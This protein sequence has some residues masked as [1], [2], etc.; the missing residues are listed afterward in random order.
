[1]PPKRRSKAPPPPSSSDSGSDSS[2]SGDDDTKTKKTKTAAKPSKAPYANVYSLTLD[3]RHADARPIARIG[4]TDEPRYLYL[5]YGS[6]DGVRSFNLPAS[7]TPTTTCLWPTLT[8]QLCGNLANAYPSKLFIAGASLSGKSYLASKI[9]RAFMAN[10]PKG[11]RIVL[12]SALA[13]DKCFDDIERIIGEERFVRLPVDDETFNEDT[14]ISLSDV[15][16]DPS[17]WKGALVIIDDHLSASSKKAVKAAERLKDSILQAGRHY[18]LSLI[19]CQQ[20]MLN[21]HQSRTTLTN[22]FQVCGYPASSG[23]HSLIAFQKKYMAMTDAQIADNMAIPS[24]W[25]LF[26]RVNPMFVMHERGCFLL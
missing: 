21:A 15:R 6:A 25:L 5:R 17:K 2:S 3:G 20:Q 22:V 14:P 18:G 12:I 16:G 11:Y 26:N 13:S 19:L 10:H 7:T 9:A 1:M 4:E 8:E 23:R 24:R